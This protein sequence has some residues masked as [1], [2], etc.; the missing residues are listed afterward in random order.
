M[1]GEDDQPVD[2]PYPAWDSLGHLIPGPDPRTPE[3][4]AEAQ[5]KENARRK[6]GGRKDWW[7]KYP[8]TDL[9]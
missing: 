9:R 3:E 2:F 1:K 5:R 4:R 8:P 7:K 6:G